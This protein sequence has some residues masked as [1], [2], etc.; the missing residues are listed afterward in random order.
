LINIWIALKN[1]AW[2]GKEFKLCWIREGRLGQYKHWEIQGS[3]YA[4]HWFEFK[5]D[6][7]FTGTDHA[8]PWVELSL[9]GFTLD[10][11]IYDSRQWN[12]QTGN[13]ANPVDY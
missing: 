6:L 8:G 3:R 9:F 1:P 5:L 4:W 2:S 11:R 13:W 10:A 7:N 12:D